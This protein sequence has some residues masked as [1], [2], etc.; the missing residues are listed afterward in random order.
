MT[1]YQ[2]NILITNAI[3]FGIS[4]SC[5]GWNLIIVFAFNRYD[6]LLSEAYW[7]LIS[8]VFFIYLRNGKRKLKGIE[9]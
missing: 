5:A 3:G 2:L 1:K 6:L 9:K 7:V 4:V 8:I